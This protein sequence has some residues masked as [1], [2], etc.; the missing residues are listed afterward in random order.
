MPIVKRCILFLLAMA[1]FSGQTARALDL[2]DPVDTPLGQQHRAELQVLTVSPTLLPSSCHL[3]REVRTAPIFPAT[4]NPFVT[5]DR[6]L[7]RFVS[8]FGFGRDTIRDVRVAMSALYADSQV[9]HEVGVWALKFTSPEAAVSALASLSRRDVL[10]RDS[11]VAT[12]WRDDDTGRA[13][14]SAIEAHLV[15]RGFT[16]R[17]AKR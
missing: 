13:C 10:V 4:T 6:A 14:Q 9:E 3:V 17:K 8:S 12:V 7:I 1:A 15:E 5:D 2:G 16:R 11:L